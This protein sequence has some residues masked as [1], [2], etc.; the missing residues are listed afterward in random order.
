MRLNENDCPFGSEVSL[1]SFHIQ[2]KL[3]SVSVIIFFN[4]SFIS[5]FCLPN[6]QYMCTFWEGHIG[7]ITNSFCVSIFVYGAQLKNVI[8]YCSTCDLLN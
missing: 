8:D 2:C 5:T 4:G 7:K 1:I 3:A 6:A